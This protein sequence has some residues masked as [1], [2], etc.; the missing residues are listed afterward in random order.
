M[1]NLGQ[2]KNAMS[3]YSYL[4]SLLSKDMGVKPSTALK[5]IYRKI[6]SFYETKEDISIDDISIKIESG[7]TK[8]VLLCDNEC[9][10]FYA[11]MRKKG[12]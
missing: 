9:F 7:S 4:T 5:N 12:M 2:T 11:I 1:L 3:H 6:E 10:K 8:G